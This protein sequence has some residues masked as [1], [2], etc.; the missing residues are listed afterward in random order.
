MF[1]IGRSLIME[2]LGIYYLIVYGSILALKGSS[3]LLFRTNESSY[4]KLFSRKKFL[5]LI[6][7]KG[8]AISDF[9]SCIFL[10]SCE[11]VRLS[12]LHYT[13]IIESSIWGVIK[14]NPRVF[15]CNYVSVSVLEVWSKNIRCHHVIRY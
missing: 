4:F 7:L 3:V 13:E 10:F 12:P 11:G 14:T 1:L 2:V 15:T 9:I 6:L 8:P 5:S